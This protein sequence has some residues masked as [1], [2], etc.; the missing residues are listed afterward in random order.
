MLR[1]PGGC[2]RTDS[3]FRTLLSRAGFRVS[4]VL[5]AGLM[6]VIEATCA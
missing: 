4:R 1:G 2:E 5:P 3:Q 6:N